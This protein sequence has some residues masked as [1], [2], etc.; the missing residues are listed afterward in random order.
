[1]TSPFCV[2]RAT[3]LIASVLIFL[4]SCGGG[5][6]GPAIQAQVQTIRFG[7]ASVLRLSGSATVTATSTSGLVVSYS[8]LTTAICSINAATGQVSAL[9]AGTCILAADQDGNDVYA[10]AAKVTQSLVVFIDPAQT[11][12]FG[13]VPTLSLYGTANVLATTSSGLPVT[14][15][16]TTPLVCSVAINTGVVT[17]VAPG[18]CTIAANQAGDANYLTAAQVT[19]TI[20]VSAVGTSSGIP[21]VPT[22]VAATLGTTPNTVAV[23]FVG[24]ANSGGTPVTGYMVVSYPGGITATGT[25]SPVVVNCPATCTGYA[26]S[27]LAI[28]GVGQ[29]ALSSSADVRT[30]YK[31]TAA[32]FEPDTQPNDTIFTGSFTINSTTASVANLRGSLTESMTGPPMVTVPLSHQLSSVSDGHGGLLVTAFALDTTNTFAE[33]GFAAGSEG[34]YFGW[35][36]AK[37][38]GAPGGVG[39]AYMTIYV[40]PSDPTAP[41]TPAQIN[42]LAYADCAAG[43]MMGDTCMTGYRGHGTMG[44]YPVS[45]TITGP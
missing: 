16:S 20:A 2:R 40:N 24:P 23:S 9:A 8:S 41:L 42:Q 1:M 39:N 10:P 33:G 12:Q 30:G 19:Q 25:A 34:L 43:G 5:G 7:T 45:Q 32:F 35:P 22:G 44:G 17:S 3:G 18:D 26:F 31:V 27:V 37:H 28:N 6:D 4:A 21:G 14:Y 15:I 36:S 13:T 29:S 11:I 38:P